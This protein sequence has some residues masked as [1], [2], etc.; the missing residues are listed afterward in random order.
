MKFVELCKPYSTATCSTKGR[1]ISLPFVTRANRMS[2]TCVSTHR[3]VSPHK[4]LLY[5]SS[6]S[7]ITN[8]LVNLLTKENWILKKTNSSSIV[9]SRSVFRGRCASSARHLKRKWTFSIMSCVS[10]LPRCVVVLGN[11]RTF[12]E[13][14]TVPGCP[15]LFRPFTPN[16]SVTSVRNPSNN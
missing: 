10:I 5:F 15:H 4:A 13:E 12:P 2:S 6:L 7:S 8:S 3:F 9:S 16:T 1:L 11:Q 14:N